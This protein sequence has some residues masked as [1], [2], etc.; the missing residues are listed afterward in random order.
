MSHISSGPGGLRPAGLTEAWIE[1][2]LSRGFPGVGVSHFSLEPVGTGQIGATYRLTPR[3]DPSGSK[4]PA[5]LILKCPPREPAARK[6]AEGTRSYKV[7]IE[8]YRNMAPKIDVRVPRLWDAT[9]DETTGDYLILMDDA[10][11]ASQGDQLLGCSAEQAQAAITEIV[12]LHAAGW[13]QPNIDLFPWIRRSPKVLRPEILA[14]LDSLVER[15]FGHFR[16]LLG[17]ATESLSKHLAE[18]LRLYALFDFE[19]KSVVHGDFRVDNLLFFTDGTRPIIVDWGGTA[20]GAPVADVSYFVGG[21]LQIHERRASEEHL[22]RSY[23]E[24]LSA[25]TRHDLTWEECWRQYAIHSVNGLSMAVLAPL[26]VKRTERGDR[27][28]VVMAERHAQQIHDLG[29]FDLLRSG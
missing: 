4:G 5:Q 9:Y 6:V 27:M 24:A 1:T 18:L 22:V 25:R 11:P 19:P 17:S 29:T 13:N 28:F 21:S 14:S 16:G 8:F 3:Y 15:Y 26:S 23:L 10:A 20:A 2:A 12:G 7:E